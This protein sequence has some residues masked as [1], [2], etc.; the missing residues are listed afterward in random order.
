MSLLVRKIDSPSFTL[1]CLMWLEGLDALVTKYHQQD[2]KPS[3]SSHISP[4]A[5]MEQV[6]VNNIIQMDELSSTPRLEIPTPLSN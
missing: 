6:F 2:L 4:F 5:R 1:L 3:H